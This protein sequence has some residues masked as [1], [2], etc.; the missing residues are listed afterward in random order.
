MFGYGGQ[1]S[2]KSQS[3]S[4]S[5]NTNTQGSKTQDNSGTKN[6]KQSESIETTVEALGGFQF[7]FKDF[8]N[9]KKLVLEACEPKLWNS[10]HHQS[11]FEPSIIE[12]KF[13]T[14]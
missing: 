9:H 1:H 5:K 7:F 11:S 12:K 6:M 14:S 13:S 4:A 2:S 3:A 8:E 10:K